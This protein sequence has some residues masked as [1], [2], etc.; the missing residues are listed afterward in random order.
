MHLRFWYNARMEKNRHTWHNRGCRRISRFA[1][2]AFLLAAGAFSFGMPA[3]ANGADAAA[4]ALGAAFLEGDGLIT[5]TWTGSGDG[6]SWNDGDNWSPDATP[7]RDYPGVKDGG[8]SDAIVFNTSADVDL[9]GG[10]YGVCDGGSKFTT[11]AGINLTLRNGTL[12]LN[13]SSY[14][15]GGHD[16]I[17][18][19]DRLSLVRG[20]VSDN[21]TAVTDFAAG[22]TVN[23][24]GNSTSDMQWR[25]TME[26]LNFTFRD[27]TIKTRYSTSTAIKTTT[28]TLITNAI[29]QMTAGDVTKGTGYITTFRDGKDRQAQLICNASIDLRSYYNVNIPA[30]GHSKPTIEAATLAAEPSTPTIAYFIL[31]VNNY[32]SDTPVPLVK[33]TTTNSTNKDNNNNRVTNQLAENKIRVY[34]RTG[35][36]DNYTDVTAKR[37]A[38]LV[39]DNTAQTIYYQQDKVKRREMVIVR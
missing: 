9:G 23:F 27:G 15:L 22:T 14:T 30:E 20:T 35:N 1:H 21:Y 29:W 24:I 5:Y 33:F 12:D 37:N 7:C 16:T 11:A 17:L 18:T 6:R 32:L 25:P 4:S 36:D 39:W 2:R 3:A 8:Y 13:H 28:C 34:A 38:R 31:Y 10:T 26:N 19:F